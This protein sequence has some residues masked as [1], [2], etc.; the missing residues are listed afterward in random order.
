MR[1]RLVAG[2]ML[3]MT[4]AAQPARAQTDEVAERARHAELVRAY[5]HSGEFSADFFVEAA[6]LR[7]LAE[8][9]DSDS[10]LPADVKAWLT[11]THQAAA[12][13]VSRAIK[14]DVEQL[15]FDTFIDRF[16]VSEM[17]AL[18]AFQ[19]FI[20]AP[21]RAAILAEAQAQPAADSEEFLRQ[22]LSPDDFSYLMRASQTP[23]VLTGFALADGI[24][25]RTTD[26]YAERFNIEI[27]LHCD[28]APKGI[29]FCER[30]YR[31]VPILRPD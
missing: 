21:E 7:L 27:R 28:S 20:D 15:I 29:E 2:V 26:N 19:Q 4:V 22:R 30:P 10:D 3:A 9:D 18:L 17:E 25:Q 23:P 8:F 12:R 24:I 16:S 11:T 5:V 31:P 14:P 13:E 6:E 1:I